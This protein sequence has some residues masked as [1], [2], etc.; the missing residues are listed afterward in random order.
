MLRAVLPLLV[1]IGL[2][3]GANAQTVSRIA[4]T[5]QVSTQISVKPAK[6]A[7][8]N[9]IFAMNPDGSGVVQLTSATANLVGPKSGRR[10]RNTS[11]LFAPII[12]W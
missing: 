2:T 7:N 4:F 8:Y 3:N 1:M 5:A 9:Q 6:Y 10:T 11:P 12:S